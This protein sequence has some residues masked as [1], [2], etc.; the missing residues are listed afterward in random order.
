[1]Q[2]LEISLRK[3]KEIDDALLKNF[4]FVLLKAQK[5]IARFYFVNSFHVTDASKKSFIKFII[6][7]C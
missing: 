3:R 1:M 6:E 7:I 4:D 5:T 2:R